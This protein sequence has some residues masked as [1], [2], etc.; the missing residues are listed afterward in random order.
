MAFHHSPNIV[1]DGLVLALD[2][3]NF[4]SYPGSGTNWSDLSN[5]GHDGTL[6]GSPFYDGQSLL[7]D[8]GTV[9]ATLNLTSAIT[10][11][12]GSDVTIIASVRPD[13]LV[14]STTVFSPRGGPTNEL[15]F[16]FSSSNLRF[17][18]YP[19]GGG[20]AISSTLSV[21]TSQWSIIAASAIYQSS[22]NFFL[23][24]E[25]ETIAHTESFTGSTPT[26][27]SI[28]AQY[29]GSSWSR[30]FDGKIGFVYVYNR[31]LNTSEVQQN[32]NASRRRFGL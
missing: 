19:A 13:T 2:A 5:L 10:S 27:V 16:G 32:Y 17:D 4:K 8:G 6:V 30:Y 31:A 23:N 25:F 21:P 3:A 28:G 7:F 11:L 12:N 26:I 18:R 22:V 29:Q 15:D 24:G 14:S 1:T 20:A 9:R